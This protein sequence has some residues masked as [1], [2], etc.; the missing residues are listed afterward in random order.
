MN[1]PNGNPEKKGNDNNDDGQRFS[2]FPAMHQT[3]ISELEQSN[4]IKLFNI[5]RIV[6]GF[7]GASIHLVQVYDSESKFLGN[8]ILKLDEIG[9]KGIEKLQREEEM[10]LKMIEASPESF[11]STHIPRIRFN[12]VTNNGQSAV[13][14]EVAGNSLRDVR[15]VNSY[16]GISELKSI[17]DEIYSKAILENWN[18][19]FKFSHGT[20]D[21]LEMFSKWLGPKVNSNT[22]REFFDSFKID[23]NAIKLIIPGQKSNVGVV[24]NVLALILKRELWSADLRIPII[25]GM[26][27]GDLNPANILVKLLR[28]GSVSE[29][30][31]IDFSDFKIDTPLLYDNAYLELSYLVRQSSL[32]F[33]NSVKLLSMLSQTNI[34]NSKNAPVSVKS[35]AEV[36]ISGRKQLEEWSKKIERDHPGSYD[37]IWDQF[38]LASV[39]AGLRFAL[40]KK[41]SPEFRYAAF[42][43]SSLCLSTYFGRL[44]F[45]LGEGKTSEINREIPS[46]ISL[47]PAENSDITEQTRHLRERSTNYYSTTYNETETEAPQNK[48]IAV[49]P[50]TNMSP[51]P[52]DEYFAD[53]MTE[54]LIDRLAQV[55]GIEVIARTSVMS[56]KG[57]KKGI[58]QIGKELRASDLV[59]GSVRKAGN[60]IRVTTQLISAATEGHLWSSHYDGNLEDIFAVQSEIAEK[61]VSELRVRLLA[62]EKAAIEKR[63]TEDTE[64]YTDYLQGIQLLN[65]FEEASLRDALG[66]FKRAVERDGRFA[67][68]QA[69][70][71]NCYVWLAARGYMSDQE[72]IE[73]GRAAAQRALD[74]DPALAEGH[75]GIAIVMYLADEIEGSMIETMKSLELNPNL[76][77]GYLALADLAAALGDKEHVVKA[78]EKAYRLDPLSPWAIEWLGRAYFWTGRGEEAMEHWKKALHLEPYRTYRLMFDYYVNK[79]DYA[80]GEEMVKEL[81]RLGPT[82]MLTYLNRGYLAAVT[83]DTKTAYDMIAKLDPGGDLGNISYAGFIYYALGDIDKF[84]DYELRAAE[85]HSLQASVIRFSPL[86]KNA[87]NDARF[88][89]VLKRAGLADLKIDSNRL[90]GL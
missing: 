36:I 21:P 58:S 50:F 13:L 88:E 23:S 46:E 77:E 66:L 81:E 37:F 69:R 1:D 26:T 54:E 55:K 15:P 83:G 51:D 31:I 89:E 52:S 16:E 67:K 40:R 25:T 47:H 22:A 48:R 10:H 34:P 86:F 39:A 43:Y 72:A 11:V 19:D 78:S 44:G 45:S 4:K 3:T 64:A 8:M 62:S 65:R 59:E 6:G 41:V 84:F 17:F 61:V 87:R 73:K 9:A 63:P 68:A 5:K 79:M 2:D 74:L 76:V 85:S 24:P 70:I 80:K 14:Y 38:F 35:Y 82:L 90:G 33:E 71:S 49:L 53:G 28:G 29:W 57:E 20:I 56:Y 42:I 12:A 30:Y 7:S 60:R 27:H 32:G 75:L 18:R